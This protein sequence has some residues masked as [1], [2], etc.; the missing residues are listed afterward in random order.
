MRPDLVAKTD[1]QFPWK[2]EI[3]QALGKLVVDHN[4]GN[5][6]DVGCGTC[7]VYHHL[8]KNGWK[9]EYV[10]VDAVAYQ[11]HTYP[12][13]IKVILGDALHIPLPQSNTYI[14]Y[15]VLEHVEDPIALLTKCIRNADNV[16]IAVPKRNEELWRRGVVEYHQLDRTHKHWGFTEHELR[17]LVKCSEGKI[18]NYEE[19]VPITL[20]GLMGA[21]TD[22]VMFCRLVEHLM[23]IYPTKTYSQELWC[24]VTKA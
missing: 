5:V 2:G 11:G 15:D 13:A 23:K 7:Q 20:L 14:L 12:E 21:F 17:R 18:V 4:R 10:G 24:E 22:N 6:V 9:G 16:L 3:N 8:L 1:I 19:L